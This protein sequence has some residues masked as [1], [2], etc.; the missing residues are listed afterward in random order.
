[1]TTV[2]AARGYPDAPEKGAAIDIPGDLGSDVLVF[3]A[4]T[5]RDQSGA[6]RTAGGRVLNV[7]GVGS[8][9]AQAARAS[10]T[11]SDRIT[12]EGK[13]WRRDIAWRELHRAGAA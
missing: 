6:L 5:S 1:M 11:A 8:S 3:H 10:R 12:F 9:V 2:L 4:G 13:I 7:T